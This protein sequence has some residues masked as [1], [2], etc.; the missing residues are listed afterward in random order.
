M[1]VGLAPFSLGFIIAIVI[2]V[3]VLILAIIGQMDWKIAALIGGLALARL[4]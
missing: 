2:L 3:L 4:T 1:Q